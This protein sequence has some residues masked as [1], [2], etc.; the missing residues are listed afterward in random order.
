MHMPNPPV[1]VYGTSWCPDCL[2][3]RRFL[4]AN[5]VLYVWIDIDGDQQGREK[6][7]LLNNGYKSVPTLVFADGSHLTEPTISELKLKIGSGNH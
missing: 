6:V 5:K 7:M 1:L 4:D 2:R 3:V